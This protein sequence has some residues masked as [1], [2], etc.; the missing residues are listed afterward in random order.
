[1]AAI[2][3][4]A[5]IRTTDRPDA[6][7]DESQDGIAGITDT[8]FVTGSPVVETLFDAPPSG[9]VL[10]FVGGGA[11]DNTSTNKIEMDYEIYEG[12]DA[13]GT[14][15]KAVSASQTGY[16]SLGGNVGGSPAGADYHYYSR[17][18]LVRGLTAGATHYARL[19]YRATGGTTADISDRQL[20]VIPA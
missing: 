17:G 16:I 2:N 8:S 18:R 9:T 11:R 15:V 3:A 19:M 5:K 4:G 20:I 10:V 7:G 12:I 13:T 14:L 6:A 1:M